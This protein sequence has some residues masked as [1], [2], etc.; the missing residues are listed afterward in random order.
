MDYPTSSE[1]LQQ[2][3]DEAILHR[4]SR[5]YD[6]LPPPSLSN[7]RS[8]P[9]PDP[10]HNDPSRH[11]LTPRPAVAHSSFPSSN[12]FH[13]ALPTSFVPPDLLR[14]SAPPDLLR[15]SPSSPGPTPAMNSFPPL[16]SAVAAPLPATAVPPPREII[17]SAHNDDASRFVSQM[18]D[19][20]D[21]HA[22][23]FPPSDPRRAVLWVVQHF[24]GKAEDWYRGLQD[25]Q[26]SAL[27]SWANLRLALLAAFSPADL[28]ARAANDLRHLT[29]T[30]SASEYSATF[31]TLAN[32]AGVPDSPFLHVWFVGGLKS[33][34]RQ[35]VQLQASVVERTNPSAA[36]R[37]LVQF[38][39]AA[40]QH[41]AQ[42]RHSGA[43]K[44]LLLAP[45][46]PTS[47]PVKPVAS[48]AAAISHVNTNPFLLSPPSPVLSSPL[49]VHA[50]SARP[51]APT[52]RPGKLSQEEVAYRIQWG[53][54]IVCGEE[55]HLKEACP[56]V[57]RSLARRMAQEE[58]KKD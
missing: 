52:R 16:P 7:P 25:I 15:P 4:L 33:S 54:C 56:V 27:L 32:R 36:W 51:P 43:A 8:S 21:L 38:S 55:G 5:H 34:V 28:A 2:L 20:L 48:Y 6:V 40:E 31:S 44:P 9:S 49:A 35:A 12:P 13:A 57:A 37:T 47:R 42:H 26:S 18:T 19:A 1:R 24:R 41:E 29:Q 14:P 45:S 11:I 39:S 50:A 22:S 46:A 10:P 23:A 3:V 17:F 30:G 53:L 58:T